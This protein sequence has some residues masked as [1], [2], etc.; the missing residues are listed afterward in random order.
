VEA[1]EMKYNL[2]LFF[3]KLFEYGAPAY[4]DRQ[5]SAILNKAQVRVFKRHYSPLA[6]IYQQGFEQTEQR[7]TDLEQLIASAEYDSEAIAPVIG[8][9]VI[10]SLNQ[11]GAHPSGVFFDMP[12]NFLYAV[13]E[14]VVTDGSSPEEVNVVPVK[15]DEYR[16]NIRN[17]YKKPYKDLVWRM[18]YSRTTHKEGTGEATAKRTEIIT[19]STSSILKYRVRYLITPSEIIVDEVTPVN[20]RHCILDATLHDEIIDEAVKVSKASVMPETYQIAD[21]EQK[22]NQS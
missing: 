19:D 14:S 20:Q 2:L 5:I 22:E 3:D 17:P 9:D 10:E 15:H 13:E 16:A 4:D 11:G 8:V 6:N 12:T 7:R 1:N 18:D 21:K